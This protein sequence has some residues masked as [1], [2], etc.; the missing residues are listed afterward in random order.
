MSL[1]K[2]CIFARSRSERKNCSHENSSQYKR[3]TEGQHRVAGIQQTMHHATYYISSYACLHH[4]NHKCNEKFC[5]CPTTSDHSKYLMK[6]SKRLYNAFD[7]VGKNLECHKIGTMIS[8]NCMSRNGLLLYEEVH[9]L[10]IHNLGIT[11]IGVVLPQDTVFPSFNCQ[12]RS[13]QLTRS[14]SIY[15][16]YSS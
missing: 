16:N 5:C 14:A 3:Y 12:N 10:Y 11:D 9:L 6:C 7:E 1:N 4:I 13:L 8:K 15:E 2:T